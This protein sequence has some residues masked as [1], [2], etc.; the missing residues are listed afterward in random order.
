M[1]DPS[2]RRKIIVGPLVKSFPFG[3]WETTVH[4][5]DMNKIKLVVPSP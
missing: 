2:A 5:A 4:H 3:M 1:L